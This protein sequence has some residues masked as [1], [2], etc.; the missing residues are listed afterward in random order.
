[1]VMIYDYYLLFMIK[2]IVV[3]CFYMFGVKG[4]ERI[5]QVFSSVR[6]FKNRRRARRP[7]QRR[8]E[9]LLLNLLSGQDVI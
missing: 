9:K 2:V 8:R 7:D 6:W 1:M 5:L 3:V 4:F